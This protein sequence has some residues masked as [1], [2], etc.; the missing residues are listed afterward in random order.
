MSKHHVNTGT[1][2]RNQNNFWVQ[3]YSPLDLKT[4]SWDRSHD[5][6]KSGQKLMSHAAA[7]E[8]ENQN[9]SYGCGDSIYDNTEQS[10][11]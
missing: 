11:C 10:A 9:E 1:N 6:L 5:I 8:C 3:G 4:S 2:R 7:C